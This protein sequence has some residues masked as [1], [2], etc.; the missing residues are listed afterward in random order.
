MALA[1]TSIN[2][3]KKRE[4]L[5]LP[6]KVKKIE[7]NLGNSQERRSKIQIE[8]KESLPIVQIHGSDL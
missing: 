8:W 1:N 7:K 2:S 3:E 4:P 6:L 5:A